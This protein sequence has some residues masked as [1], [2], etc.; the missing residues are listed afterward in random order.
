MKVVPTS[1]DGTVPPE[2]IFAK[3]GE[4][5]LAAGDAFGKTLR[6]ADESK[7]GL[8]DAGFEGVAEHRFKLP[9]SDWPKDERL[10]IIGAYN[11]A[12]WESG[13]EGWCMFLLT[14]YLGWSRDEVL[15][16]VAE[17][18]RMLRDRSVHAYHE[19]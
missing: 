17:M 13:M 8:I 15:V 4:V 2:S 10:K 11:K 7:Q 1:D 12:H 14:N 16:Y 19:W 5:S 9:M 3:W 18:R 6:C